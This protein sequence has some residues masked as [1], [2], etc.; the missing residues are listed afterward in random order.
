MTGPPHETGGLPALLDGWREARLDLLLAE[1]L[2]VNPRF[3]NHLSRQAL[4]D[5]GH[6]APDGDPEK[7]DVAFNVW[8][9]VD[10]GNAGENDLDV[11]LIWPDGTSRRLLVED[12]VWAPMQPRQ[13]ERYRARAEACGGAAVLVAPSGW[14]RGHEE[15]A[16]I[17]HGLH[18]LEALAGWL[19]DNCSDEEN[20]RLKWRADL[21]CAL[22]AP[23]RAGTAIDH[24]PTIDFRDYCVR[25]LAEVDSACDPQ[26][27]SLHTE[28][29]GWLWFSHPKDLGFKATHGRIDLYAAVNGF[30]GTAEELRDY[31][32]EVALPSG[33]AVARDTS[34]N[35]VIRYEC[36]RFETAAGTPA[37]T[38]SLDEALDA[39]VRITKWFDEGGADLLGRGQGREREGSGL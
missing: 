14:I 31:A 15:A 19:N 18:T 27:L 24:L 21:L 20:T 39:C 38:M 36:A 26:L 4:D 30:K 6:P 33:F 7:V 12:K 5:A 37:V 16:K 23:R 25:W 13:A 8:H 1:E 11:R 9:Q 17:F 2:S 3:A 32:A 28:N 34:G 22:A 35:V 10:D 29:Q